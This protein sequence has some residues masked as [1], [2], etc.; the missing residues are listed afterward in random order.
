MEKAGGDRKDPYLMDHNQVEFQMEDAVDGEECK[1][2]T[3]FD[4]L[5]EI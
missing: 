5:E 4:N 2:G 3:D 1:R